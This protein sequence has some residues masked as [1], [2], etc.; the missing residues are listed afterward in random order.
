MSYYFSALISHAFGYVASPTQYS[1]EKRLNLDLEQRKRATESEK[2]RFSNDQLVVANSSPGF[3]DSPCSDTLGAEESGSLRHFY[4][5][6][7]LTAYNYSAKMT[8]V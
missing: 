5:S 2:P 4:D 6:R 3:V 1:D 8:Q 7:P